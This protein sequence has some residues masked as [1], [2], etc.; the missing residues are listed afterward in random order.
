MTTDE[1]DRKTS[2]AGSARKVLNMLLLFDERRPSATVAELAELVDIPT[3]SAYRYVS[4]LKELGLVEE[5]S[6]NRYS[7]SA[8]IIP[9]ARAA[10]LSNPIVNLA[11][12]AMRALVATLDETVL[13]MQY[14]SEQAV[15]IQAVECDRPMRYTFQPGHS[16]PLGRGASG[17]LLLALLPDARREAWLRTNDAS[18]ALREELIEAA[19]EGRATSS[20]E[21]HSG[22]WAC[23]VP[24]VS[25]GGRPIV[26]STAGPASRI[27]ETAREEVL[28]ILRAGAADIRDELARFS[29]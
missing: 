5:S 21:L 25:A 26:L 12:P 3:P 6:P 11:L 7:P 1:G 27:S 15:C 28:R 2:G 16:M 10:Q 19:R 29:L 20:G 18:R 22:L 9:V 13:L 24:V 4:L 8:R 17:K 14:A 23:S